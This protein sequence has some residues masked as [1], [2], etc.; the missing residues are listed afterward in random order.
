[1][2]FF[3]LQIVRP[4]KDDFKWNEL[5]GNGK[6]F[7]QRNWNIEKISNCIMFMEKK[8][9]QDKHQEVPK[10]HTKVIKLH[11]FFGINY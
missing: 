3:C 6:N 1:L 10:I 2:K 4:L 7:F 9:D 11:Y 5:L 8:N